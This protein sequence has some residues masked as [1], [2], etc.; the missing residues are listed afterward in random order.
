MKNIILTLLCCLLLAVLVNHAASVDYGAYNFSAAGRKL[1]PVPSGH[2]PGKDNGPGKGMHNA[3]E[4]CGIC[5]TPAGKAPQY[6][7]T[8]SGT[9]YEDRAAGKALPGAEI[10]LQDIN[11]HIVSMT[12]NDA[13]NFWTYTPLGSNPRSVANHGVTEVLYRND[14]DG[15]FIPADPADTRTWQYKTWVRS[16]DRFIGM[17]TIAPVGGASDPASRMSCNMHHSMRGSRGALWVSAKSTLSAYPSTGL[18]FRNH[19]LPIFMGKCVP[20][21]IPGKT[22]TRPV[23]ESD[24]ASPPTSVDFSKGLDLTSYAGSNAESVA[25]RGA[26]DLAVPFQSNPDASPILFMP[27]SPE[28]HPAGRIWAAADLD[29]RAIRRWIAEGAQNN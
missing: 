28:L 20:C 22:M 9:V 5:H 26:G 25:K 14:K 3:G 18:S 6:L 15:K 27:S 16:G 29:Y 23:T 4:D 10:I 13:G 8:M 17:V 11:G 7:F 12:S 24:I 19:I 2:V 1:Q 21:H